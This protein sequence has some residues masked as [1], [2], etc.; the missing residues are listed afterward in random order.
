MT[1]DAA[2]ISR[3]STVRRFHRKPTAICLLGALTNASVY[4]AG[5]I[6]KVAVVQL[7]RNFR[8]ARRSSLRLSVSSKDSESRS[9]STA[10]ALLRYAAPIMA[11]ICGVCMTVIAATV[12]TTLSAIGSS[13]LRDGL[14]VEGCRFRVVS[15]VLEVTRCGLHAI[16]GLRQ[17]G[18][19][20]T[21]DLRATAALP[22][23]LE[24]E[25]GGEKSLKLTS[26]TKDRQ[27]IR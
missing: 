17:A 9:I 15:A 26:V 20:L 5:T 4:K 6:S 27:T 22:S 12:T 10:T 25:E 19:V 14:M 23:L 24:L 11:T 1:N 3:V 2:L 13:C 7:S 21:G 16:I 18:I 8:L